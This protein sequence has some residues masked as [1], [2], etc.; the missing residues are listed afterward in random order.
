[1]RD[2]SMDRCLAAQAEAIWPQESRLLSAYALPR[3]VRVLD[4]GCGTGQFTTRLHALLPDASITGIDILPERIA[5]LKAQ[6][7][8]GLDFA[9][10]D[11]FHLDFEDGVFDF[12]AC[13]HVLQSIPEPEQA[14]HELRRVLKPGG[15]IHL[16]AE[17]YG[18]LHFHPAR[19]DLDQFFHNNGRCLR[20]KTGV[21]FASGRHAPYW[22]ET[23][24]FNTIGVEYL[25]VDTLRVPRLI[26]REIFLS[27]RD[28]YTSLVSEVTGLARD[29][30][31]A[32]FEDMIA[33]VSHPPGYAVW[34]VP[35]VTGLKP[36]DPKASRS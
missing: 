4:A 27:W 19:H 10:G 5:S 34:F 28:G 35:V 20:E 9:Q 15:R 14:L 30:V 32:R 29:E 33:C 11:I 31:S 26:L 22:L 1:M 7:G 16:L 24:G 18:M 23:L 12:V 13:R 2:E 6:A 36:R 3:G 21:D 25:I 8:P 17:D